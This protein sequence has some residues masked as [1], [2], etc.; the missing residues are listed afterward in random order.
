MRCP[1]SNGQMP[2][3]A[4][5]FTQAASTLRTLRGVLAALRSYEAVDVAMR[6]AIVAGISVDDHVDQGAGV[7]TRGDHGPELHARLRLVGLSQ[8]HR[9]QH[10][11]ACCATCCP[12]RIMIN[13]DR[14]LT[15][16]A[17][18]SL[19]TPLPTSIGG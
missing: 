12:R 8:R 1:H 17:A 18:T 14:I 4:A 11:P 7:G 16:L 2:P 5:H 13:N 3:G 19:M 10:R 9:V 6:K 15:N